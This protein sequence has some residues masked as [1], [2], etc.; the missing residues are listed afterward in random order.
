MEMI[1]S[2][3]SIEKFREFL[4][5][6]GRSSMTVKSYCADM[7]GFLQWASTKQ[8]QGKSLELQAALYLN[9][10]RETAAPKTTLRRLTSMRAYARW[11]GSDSFLKDYI[12]PKPA[13]PQPHPLEGG[14]ADVRKMI[15]YAGTAD[16][17][18]LM[19]LLGLQGCRV[20]EA[21]S[22]R[23][24]HIDLQRMQLTIRGKGDKTRIVPLSDEAWGH[25]QDAFFRAVKNGTPL[26]NL[27]DSCARGHV[28]RIARRAGIER[29][30]SSH[31]GRATFATSMLNAGAN[32]RTVQEALG[33][34][35]LV[36]TEVYTGVTMD[37]MRE[38]I[39][40]Q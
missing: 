34:A 30:V 29:R 12:A 14:I 10:T 13:K 3:E 25:M 6:K 22:I 38:A 7:T 36:T 40:F 1:L 26:V 39:T 8:L 21:R 32:I 9:E 27:N 23:P 4:S 2:T 17:K 20:S 19:A 15:S 5:A 28:T 18:A 11:M 35:S 33:H 37:Q 24:E 16:T 31:D